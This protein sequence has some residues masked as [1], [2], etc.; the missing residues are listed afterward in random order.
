MCAL[1]HTVLGLLGGL[2]AFLLAQA[3]SAA[4]LVL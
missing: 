2:P 1:L 4:A 3:W